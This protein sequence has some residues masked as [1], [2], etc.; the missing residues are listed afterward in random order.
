MNMNSIS[1]SDEVVRP[2]G[3]GNWGLSAKLMGAYSVLLLLASAALVLGLYLQ[4]RDEQR[5]AVKEQLGTILTYARPQ[6]DV[7]FLARIQTADDEVSSSYLLVQKRLQ[8]MQATLPTIRRI[9]ILRQQPDGSW[10]YIVDAGLT[11]QAPVSVGTPYEHPLKFSATAGITETQT[12]DNWHNEQGMALWSGYVPIAD[13][14]NQKIGLLGIDLDAA[15]IVAGQNRAMAMAGW[16]FGISI[17]FLLVSGWVVTRQLLSPIGELAIAAQR[18][19]AGDLERPVPVS[20][21]DELGVLAGSFNGM[22]EQLRALIGSLEERVAER[23]AALER[24]SAYLQASADISRATAVILETGQLLDEVVE[25][26]RERFNLYHVGLFL[27]DETRQ[28]VVLRAAAGVGAAALLERRFQLS[29]DDH[30]SMIGWVMTHGRSC[31]AQPVTES[32]LY[33]VIEELQAVQSVLALPLRSRGL[34]IGALSI[35]SDREQAFDETM[36]TVLHTMADQVGATLEN[37]RL[38]EEVQARAEELSRARDEAE[39][40]R[41]EAEEAKARAE[42]ALNEAESANRALEAQMWQTIGQAQ[43]NE[44]MRGEQD[45]PT[46]ARN[47]IRQLC[48]YLEAQAGVLYLV[49]E[50]RVRRVGGYAYNPPPGSVDAFKVGEGLVGQVALDQRMLVFSEVPADYWVIASGMGRISPRQL[51]IAPLVFARQTIGVLEI[52][53]LYNLTPA[54]QD[55][56]QTALESMA[57]AFTTALARSRINLLL[58]QTQQQ[59]EALQA[60][61][62]ELWATNEELESQTE[63]LRASEARLRENQHQLQA[64]NAEL[65]ESSAALRQNQE[66]L[67]LQNQELRVARGEL[68]RKAEELALASKY[69]S[70]FL[71][72]MSHELRT[73]LNSLLILARMLS[74]NDSG[75]LTPQQVESAQIIYNSGSDLLNLINEILDLSKVEAGRM[76]FFI[77]PMALSELTQV[78]QVQFSHVA[79]EK[80]L[81]FEVSVA[82]DL[83]SQIE[84]DFKRVAQIV[85]NLLSNAFKFTARGS[86]RLVIERAGVQDDLSRSALKP[87][88]TV[89]IRVSDSGIG[90]TP[91]QQKIVFEAF[92]QADGSTSRK[93]GGTGLGLT[94]S[95]EMSTRLGGFISLRSEYHKGT[96]FTLYLPFQGTAVAPTAPVVAAEPVV[97]PAPVEVVAPVPVE[98]LSGSSSDDRAML[99]PGDRV[100]L[101]VEDDHRFA[102]IVYDYAHRNRFKCLVAGNGE[103]GIMLAQ[104]YLPQAIILDL[105]LPGISG[106]EVLDALK[107]TPQTRHI[108]VHIISVADETVRAYQRGAMGFISKPVSA[109][110]LD[111]AFQ[112]IETFIAR[113][114]K[115]LLLVEDDSQLRHSIRQLLAGADINFFEASRAQEALDLLR[116]QELD[117]MILDLNLPD[118]SGF[119]LLNR[120][121]SSS[122]VRRCPIIIYTG[123]ELSQEENLELMRYADSVIIKG[124][125]SPERLLDETALFLH[126]VVAELP[127][128]HQQTIQQ[129]RTQE[130]VLADRHILVV[131]D[132]MRSAFALSRLLREKGLHV[133]IAN[134]GAKALQL[135]DTTEGIDLVLMDIMMPE[136]DGYETMHHIRAQARFATLPVLALTAK[137]MKGDQEKCLAAGANDYLAKPVDLDRLFSLLR[138]W[139]YR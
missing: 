17:L 78:M 19:A 25:L 138:V 58:S 82:E 43:L 42:A 3:L 15:A 107:R 85:K 4:L 55:F 89:A 132:D 93:Y 110:Q 33:S 41:R 101:V 83:P 66:T 45:I 139:L 130:T 84:S 52:A 90:M 46:L 104:K 134:S 73:P 22:M 103:A 75:N 92:Q 67:D 118:M 124:V 24:R 125:K 114:V 133:T 129:L 136:M 50:E 5:R 77:A 111:H 40:T 23:T 113:K 30:S 98:A 79:E 62:E 120:L 53:M 74:N 88:S 44:R 94:I 119:E 86:V 131:D 37:A 99:Q 2:G 7:D 126:R 35:Q 108:P 72:N 117:C 61:K 128:E 96:V 36:S 115:N 123:R 34:V 29:I 39:H 21:R 26:I 121:D 127:Q 105:N 69:K 56:L 12:E 14:D 60:Q 49:E 13:R 91:E 27:I 71:A 97:R 1:Q 16:V 65:E 76:E 80:G 18:V 11:G 109:E 59:T 54:Q 95:R 20:S 122:E 6:V 28:S 8:S 68:E 100:L 87:E 48:Q 112:R 57:I 9:Y 106:W 135:L 10:I 63:S 31:V 70:E 38:F 81:E 47:T 116:D 102:R 137:A 32:A 51:V 64:A